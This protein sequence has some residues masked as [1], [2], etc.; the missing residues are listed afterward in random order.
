M[1]KALDPKDDIGRLYM[2][3]KEGGRG[4]AGIED[5]VDISM[6]RKLR[7]KELRKTNYDNQKQ[8]KNTSVNGTK[9]TRKKIGG[10]KTV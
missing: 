10:K 5:S 6:T 7:K 3:R 2:G 8:H 1:H 4:L 9:I